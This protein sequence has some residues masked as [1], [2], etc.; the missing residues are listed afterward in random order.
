MA[1][2]QWYRCSHCNRNVAVNHDEGDSEWCPVCG[3]PMSECH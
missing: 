2:I 3:Y 1:N